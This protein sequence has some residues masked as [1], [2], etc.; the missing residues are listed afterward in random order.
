MFD[1]KL[2]LKKFT[3]NNPL[4]SVITVIMIVFV[5]GAIISHLG[6]FAAFAFLV[7]TV[8]ILLFYMAHMFAW[9]WL[10]IAGN[11]L[12]EF[13]S[14]KYKQGLSQNWFKKDDYNIGG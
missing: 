7:K 9:E 5:Y 12:I 6:L 11:S 10:K 3:F 13:I 1:K 4:W 14:S 2:S 8:L